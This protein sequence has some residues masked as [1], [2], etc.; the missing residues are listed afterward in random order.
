MTVTLSSINL[1]A[2]WPII[3]LLAVLTVAWLLVELL[4]VKRKVSA[5]ESEPENATTSLPYVVR[6]G[7]LTQGE[8][9]FFPV[10]LQAARIVA[11]DRQAPDP[12]VLAKVRLADI[13]EVQQPELRS[14]KGGSDFATL[15]PSQRTTAQNRINAKHVDFVLCHPQTTR[16]LLVIELDDSSHRE[17]RRQARD[18]FV[19]RVCA[20]GPRPIAVL[21]VRAAGSYDASKIAGQIQQALDSTRHAAATSAPSRR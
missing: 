7:V 12:L 11:A 4:R 15:T 9:A 13:V 21:H 2:F 16:P 18:E 20:S 3:A 6:E 19:D 17:P 10:L 8:R 1:T 5:T 14:D